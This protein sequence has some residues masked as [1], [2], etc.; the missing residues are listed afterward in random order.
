MTAP[1]TCRNCVH[2]DPLFKGTTWGVK[3]VLDAP[4]VELEVLKTRMI[5]QEARDGYVDVDA[6]D[7][8]GGTFDYRG[9]S[10]ASSDASSKHPWW[11]WGHCM[12]T[13]HKEDEQSETLARA[14]DGSN[15]YAVLQ[16]HHTFGCVQHRAE[17]VKKSA[18]MSGDKELPL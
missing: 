2:W 11:E 14:I 15:Y 8:H 4:Q 13:T 10:R 1:N 16:T 3:C 18:A 12:L 6:L 7:N 17:K 5:Q 9:V